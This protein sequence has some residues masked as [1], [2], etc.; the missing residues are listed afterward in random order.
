M[1]HGQSEWNYSTCSLYLEPFICQIKDTE[2]VQRSVRQKRFNICRK[3]LEK[4]TK[5]YR[6]QMLLIVLKLITQLER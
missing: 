6:T 3:K 1:A 2:A 5:R 4:V